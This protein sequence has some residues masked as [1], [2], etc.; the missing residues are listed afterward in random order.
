MDIKRTPC[1]LGVLYERRAVRSYTDEALDR[2]MVEALLDAAIQA[3]TAMHQEPWS[4]VVVQD[5]SRLRDW[6]DRAKAMS[7]AHERLADP[8][9]TAPGRGP[10][11]DPAFNI[12]Y[13]AGTLIVVCRKIAGAYAEADCWLAAQNLML[14]ATANGLGSCCIGLAVSVLNEP[15]VKQALGIP[16]AGA[17]V[18]PIIVGV[19]RGVPTPVGRQPAQ[20]LSWW[21]PEPGSGA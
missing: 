6:S 21:G 20:V 4:F 1:R 18:A 7:R 5:R 14:A 17:A 13:D 10:L 9:A 15:D 11:S 8:P 16:P 19:S 3:P 2:P 12:F